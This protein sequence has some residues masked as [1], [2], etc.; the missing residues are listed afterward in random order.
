MS[1]TAELA[2]TYAALILND[3]D[4]EITAAKLEALTKAAKV[5]VDSYWFGLFADALK[6]QDIGALISNVGVGGGAAAPA[7]GGAAPAAG[8]AAPAAAAA[9]E[10]EEESEED[11][12]DFGLFD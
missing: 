9:P 2:V 1:N 11:D 12:M 4:V 8:G 10:P 5:N 7:A 3:D 6:G